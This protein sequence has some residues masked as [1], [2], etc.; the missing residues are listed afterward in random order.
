MYSLNLGTFFFFLTQYQKG[1]DCSILGFSCFRDGPGT[2][3]GNFWA[4]WQH[5]LLMNEEA[6]R[7]SHLTLLLGNQRWSLGI[8]HRAPKQLCF[9][10]DSVKWRLEVGDW[11]LQS[12]FFSVWSFF[13][14]FFNIMAAPSA[15]GSSRARNWIQA[16][17][18]AAPAPLTHCTG[19][20]IKPVPL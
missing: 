14:F 20:G 4:A 17:D 13:F 5:F 9:S 11:Y 2:Q 10:F 7:E 6:W 16:A 12:R 8:L 18:V 15:Y 1:H 3:A 19:P